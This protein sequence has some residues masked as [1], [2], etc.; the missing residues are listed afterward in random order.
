M[1]VDGN[2]GE[3]LS[4]AE[5]AARSTGLAAWLV[6]RGIGPGERV[7]VA[8]PNGPGWAV[9]ALGVWRAGGALVPVN[10][11]APAED[12]GRVLGLV[13][14]RIALTSEPFAPLTRAAL[15]AA[16]VAA[17]VVTA[18]D[19]AIAGASAFAEPRRRQEG[20]AVVPFSSGTGGLP[21]GVRLTHG[22]LSAASGQLASIYGSAGSFGPDSVVLAGVPPFHIMGLLTGLCAPLRAAARIVTL[23]APDGR[24]ALELMAEHR[25]THATLSLPAL[26][27]IAEMNVDGL[28]LSRLEFVATA[29]AHAPVGLQ[30]RVAERL[31]CTVRQGYG[32]T[33]ASPIS[34]P[35]GEP[36]D[37]ESVGRLVAGTEARLVEP[38]S[39][40]EAPPGRAGELWIRGPQ[41]MQG[42]YDDREATAA[43][44]TPD[45]WLRTGDLVT[46]RD[47][48]QLVIL[49]RL[50]EL[51]KVHGASVAPAEVELVLR[52]HPSVR[53]A[54]VV[55]RP[56]ADAGEVPV[57][58]V[59]LRAPATPRELISFVGPRVAEHRR[60][61]DVQI[62]PAL[63]RLPNGKLLRRMLRDRER[64]AVR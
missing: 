45:G 49:D 28:D 26:D 36:V 8:L 3:R 53:D 25:V 24:R 55:G 14:P 1:I 22:N 54:A 60:L 59:V 21:K 38:E 37:P 13:R 5:L 39:G 42:Y 43:A 29:G 40:R 35:L 62:V 61:H 16:G 64:A 10:V 4:R 46:I 31:R 7:A 30:R 41:V 18:D 12:T 6:A 58:Y 34:G 27:E 32:M 33:E 2:T 50:K 20:L 23:A 15:A 56:D 63:P 11:V 52:E 44:I 48:G 17:E 19:A 51:I 57:A 9:A 47:D